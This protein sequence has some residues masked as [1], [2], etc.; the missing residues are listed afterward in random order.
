MAGVPY[1]GAGV[2]A[3]AAGMDK[4]FTKKLAVA[5]AIPVGPCVVLR[6]GQVHFGLR[7]RQSFSSFLAP[8]KG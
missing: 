6:A 1:V 3:S 2:F 5:E 7:R 8:Q 4:E